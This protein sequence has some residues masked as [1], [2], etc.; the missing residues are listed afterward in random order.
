[1]R[2]GHWLSIMLNMVCIPPCFNAINIKKCVALISSGFLPVCMKNGHYTVNTHTH[3]RFMSLSLGQP[4]LAST[5]R[6]IHPLTPENMLWESIMILDFMRRGEDNRGKYA[7]NL[8]LSRP[9]MPPPPSS[10]HFTL[11]DLAATPSNLF[12]LGTGTKY[13]GLHTWRFA[14]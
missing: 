7:D 2:P 9:S 5:R 12:C 13:A 3:C 1:M 6:D 10:P 14:L 4:R 11:E 8:V